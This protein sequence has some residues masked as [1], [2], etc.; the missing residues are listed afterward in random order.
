MLIVVVS[1]RIIAFFKPEFRSVGLIS[2]QINPK[3]FKEA[4]FTYWSSLLA[5][6]QSIE[7][8]SSH[9]PRGIS[10]AAIAA[11]RLAI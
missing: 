8:N 10:I 7:I 9:S 6:A 5:F 3:V 1:A 2:S 11:T 4:S